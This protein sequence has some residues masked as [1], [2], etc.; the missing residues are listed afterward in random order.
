MKI[1]IRLWI[2]GGIISAA[3]G[4]YYIRFHLEYD[5]SLKET[6]STIILPDRGLKA[7]PE[8]SQGNDEEEQSGFTEFPLRQ[9]EISPTRA[10]LQKSELDG[11]AESLNDSKGHQSWWLTLQV[12]AYL[13]QPED[14]GPIIQDFIRRREDTTGLQGNELYWIFGRKAMAVSLLG[15]TRTEADIETLHQIIELE[16]AKELVGNWIDQIPKNGLY[17]SEYEIYD[18]VQGRAGRGLA[19]A[20]D[21]T[22]TALLRSTYEDFKR[23]VTAHNYD[24]PST[25][26]SAY[27]ASVFGQ[28]A[29]AMALNDFIQP[30]DRR[31]ITY[32][33]LFT[34]G[35]QTLVM[36]E[37]G[38]KYRFNYWEE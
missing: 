37:Y 14:A 18:L 17:E 12:V 11:W 15:V 31:Y 20:G 28:L 34:R 13:G 26:I 2:Y 7:A 8:E 4:L 3:L 35:F 19:Y 23:R 6:T 30:R 29:D 16:G 10:P 33:I 1:R 24:G 9:F 21:S 5:P 22:S 27:E 25:T 36:R 32:D 38:E